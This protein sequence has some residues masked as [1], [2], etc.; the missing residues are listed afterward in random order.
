MALT[1]TAVRS[2]RPTDKIQRIRDERGLYLEVRPNGNKFWRFRYWIDKR[3]RILSLGP[4]PEI[5]LREARD[6]REETRKL[7]AEGKDPA[8]VK[9][10][11]REEADAPADTFEPI[12]RE[13]HARKSKT[14]VIE[15]SEKIIR[16]FE[17]YVFPWLGAKPIREIGAPDL[18]ACLRRVEDKGTVETAHRV[19][20]ICSQVFRYAIAT[21]RAERDPAGDLRGAL[22]PVKGDHRA[23]ITDPAGAGAL[24]RAIDSYTG[25]FTTRVALRFGALTFVRPGE[26]RHA[27][28]EEIDVGRAEWRIPAAKMKMRDQHIV[29]L[30][31]QALELLDELRPLTG[32]GKYLFPCTRSDTRP[33][34]EVTILAALRRLGYSKEEMTGHGFRAMASTLLNEAGWPPDVIERQLAHM[35]RNKVRAAYNRAQLL[36]ERRRMMQAWANFL[37]DL[38]AGE[39][40]DLSPT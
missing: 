2:F 40:G 29:P 33:M 8:E 11:A 10:A 3:E 39:G 18:L 28:W 12:A 37:A 36:P 19:H 35:E 38:E 4:Y 24:M 32:A 27:E 5:S 15:H 9:K 16:R 34:S 21:G 20:Q 26:L 6:R 13:W 23:A 17:L 1:D 22:T 31:T 30:A 14:W 7:L 25:G